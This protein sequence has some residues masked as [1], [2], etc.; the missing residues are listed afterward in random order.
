VPQEI[1]ELGMKLDIFGGNAAP[2]AIRAY[3]ASLPPHRSV[4]CVA[5]ARYLR[6]RLL[7]GGMAFTSARC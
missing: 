7:T 1:T 6:T 2:T 5:S 4:G 3:Q